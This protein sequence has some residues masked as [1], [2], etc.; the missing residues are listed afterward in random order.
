MPFFCG[1]VVP[2]TPYDWNFTT[3]PQVGLNGRSVAYPRGHI[4]GGTSSVS[5]SLSS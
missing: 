2:N 1:S 3:T 4:L 5:E